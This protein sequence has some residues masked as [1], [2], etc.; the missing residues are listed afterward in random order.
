MHARVASTRPVDALPWGRLG[1]AVA[2]RPAANAEIT[3]HAAAGRTVAVRGDGI[4]PPVQAQA[5]GQSPHPVPPSRQPGRHQRHP[6]RTSGQRWPPA[7]AP[8]A[9]L[10]ASPGRA[11]RRPAVVGRARILIP[12]NTDRRRGRFTAFPRP[13]ASAPAG[14]PKP[15]EGNPPNTRWPPPGTWC[16][17]SV[18]GSTLGR[19]VHLRRRRHPG[20]PWRRRRRI[21]PAT[22]HP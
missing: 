6:A 19:P 20:H 11:G 16:K 13:G 18:S 4:N 7:G 17:R 12:H 1:P 14:S 22:P 3:G 21:P 5:G 2:A 8:G 10:G 9:A 15:S